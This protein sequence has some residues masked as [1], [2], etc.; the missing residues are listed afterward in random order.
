MRPPTTLRS[1]WPPCR[2]TMLFQGETRREPGM[3][4]KYW[5]CARWGESVGGGEAAIAMAMGVR[6]ISAAVTPTGHA[7]VLMWKHSAREREL[8][9]RQL[10]SARASRPHLSAI[11]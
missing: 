10:R 5:Y 4:E 1:M 2:M 6:L 7:W 3:G 9:D 8:H 11:P